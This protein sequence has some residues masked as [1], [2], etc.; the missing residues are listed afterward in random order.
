V[1]DA[2]SPREAR[3]L[4][5]RFEG[6]FDAL[7]TDV[8]LPEMTGRELAELLCAE[9]PRLRVLYTSGY[10]ENTIVHH[11]VVDGGIDFL[12]KP[13]VST[14]LARRVRELLDRDGPPDG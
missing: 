3:A 5:A 13:Y 1:H 14:E 11:G 6:R 10:T 12:P 2:A 4:F 9:N 7:I 8:R